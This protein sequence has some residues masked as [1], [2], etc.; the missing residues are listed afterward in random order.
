MSI[1]WSFGRGVLHR[2]HRCPR[3]CGISQGSCGGVQPRSRKHAGVLTLIRVRKIGF[4][5]LKAD[6]Q[7]CKYQYSPHGLV[8]VRIGVESFTVKISGSRTK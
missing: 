8:D 6:N 5:F 7:Q 3:C 4:E 2:C 1:L